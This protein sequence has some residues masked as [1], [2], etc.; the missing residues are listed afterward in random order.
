MKQILYIILALFALSMSAQETVSFY[1][2]TREL[3]NIQSIQKEA[4]D[5]IVDANYGLDN[6]VFWFKI[7]QID[8]II[9]M[10]T[11]PSN[12][13]G[14]LQLFDSNGQPIPIM[15]N[16][17]YPSFTLNVQKHEFPVYLKANFQQEAYFP[18]QIV[19]ADKFVSTEK[20]DLLGTG[21]YYGALLSLIL[22]TFVFF[23]ITKKRVF[24]FHALL[25]VVIA[26]TIVAK[27]NLFY[28][29]N[30]DFAYFVHL[31]LF[32][33]FL[34]GFFGLCFVYLCIN[35][36][37]QKKRFGY[38]LII[39]TSFSMLTMLAY[40]ATYDMVFFFISDLF[41][42]GSILTVWI[43]GMFK[44][45]RKIIN[46]LIGTVYV[47]NIFLII[48]VFLLH[49]IGNTFFGLSVTAAKYCALLDVVLITFAMLYTF[50]KMKHKESLMKKQVRHYFQRLE[51][52]D[53][54]KKA[55]DEDDTYLET[56]INEFGLANVEVK[57]LQ[58]IAKG[59]SHDHIAS[60][61]NMSE[62]DVAFAAKSLFHK[63][64]IEADREIRVLVS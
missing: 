3:H 13:A 61:F 37:S 27:D 55:Q 39:T 18:I 62:D 56:L 32:S 15:A 35:L 57:I 41:T 7:S 38:I 12:H 26:L 34:V 10:L 48:E 5:P 16:T 19:E 11:I 40:F 31:E 22:A 58:G 29:L 52:L 24:L 64:G 8:Q 36:N 1:Q 63:L 33:H 45:K 21:I 23:F 44:I 30:I 42:L 28:L 20:Y 14:S 9:E 53:Q 25:A 6:G 60:D 59:H 43:I 50:R 17:R 46:W 54:Y 2:D 49:T 47:I 51:T 4:F